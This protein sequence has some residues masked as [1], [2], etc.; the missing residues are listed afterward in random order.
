MTELNNK[1]IKIVDLIARGYTTKDIAHNLNLSENT[2]D[3]YIK[4]I[5]LKLGA[6]NRPNMVLIAHQRGLI[7]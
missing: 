5:I 4:I 2:I 6:I 7:L 3:T 1:E